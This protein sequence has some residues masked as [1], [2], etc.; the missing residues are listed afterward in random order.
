ML[1]CG[2]SPRMRGKPEA[3]YGSF[4]SFA[5]HPRVCG[6]N[7]GM[8]CIS[9]RAIGTSP[10]MRGKLSEIYPRQKNQRNIPAYAGKTPAHP[11]YRPGRREHP[12]V[13]G[14][15]MRLFSGSDGTNGTSPRMRGKPTRP[16]NQSDPTRNIPAYAGKTPPKD[17]STFQNAG[18]SP[19]MRGK[20]IGGF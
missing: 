11:C 2:T 9:S 7:T 20:R 5:E 12:R 16:S 1:F 6:E 18:T 19:R 13:C 14:E 17:S 15:N 8:M 3:D 10:R 4:S